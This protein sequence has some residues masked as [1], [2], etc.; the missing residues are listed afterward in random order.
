MTLPRSSLVVRLGVAFFDYALIAVI[1]AIGALGWLAVCLGFDPDPVHIWGGCASLIVGWVL[2][3]LVLSLRMP[4]TWSWRVL[5][6]VAVLAIGT[7][8]W[9][10]LR[11]VTLELANAGHVA[12]NRY[13]LIVQAGVFL[14]CW[15]SLFVFRRW[16]LKRGL[17][18]AVGRTVLAAV[19]AG[20]VIYLVRDEP[21]SPS[22]GR[23]RAAMAGRS[24]NEA[25]R[26]LTLRYSAAPGG[27]KVFT[28][29]THKLDFHFKGEQQQ[30]YLLAHRA[31]LEANWAELAEVRA[32]WAEMAAQPQL[33]DHRYENFEEP[34]IRFQPVR[35]YAQHALAIATLQALDGDGDAA[36]ATVGEVYKVGSLLEPASCTLTRSMI[37]VVTQKQ[38]LETAEF[39]VGHTRLSADARARFAALLDASN[40]GALGAK[41][42]ILTE[43]TS[44]LWTAP[45]I[46]TLAASIERFTGDNWAVHAGQRVN[47]SLLALTLNPQATINRMHEHYERFA[48][49][50]EARDF[51]GM[52][53][54]G[55]DINVTPLG[56]FQVKNISGRLLVAMWL[57][58]YSK[59]VK[60]YWETEDMRAAL[61]KHLME[62]PPPA[63]I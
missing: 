43:S 24:E 27:G 21:E 42:L 25:T 52:E 36:L 32:W 45:R 56:A 2:L 3:G 6:S 46:A 39:V 59:I 51:A 22:V 9:V 5:S 55:K 15:V 41:R 26:V 30:A 29:P 38:A 60:T 31:E 62:T 11:G 23:N 54:L 63:A 58:A 37:A 7:L 33:G 40:G 47:M 19:V 57:P 13:L 14:F 44:I 35:A 12:E 16:A 48:L 10:W 49:C 61:A 53:V 34:I 1:S 20:C 17:F 4:R 8:S 18:S 50:A 28:L